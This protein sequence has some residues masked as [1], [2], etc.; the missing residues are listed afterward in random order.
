MW[1]T[2]RTWAV[3]EFLTAVLANEQVRDNMLA[4]TPVVGEYRLFC[5]APTV[6]ETVIGLNY[7][8]CNGASV[9]RSNYSLLYN[10]LN[11]MRVTRG[12][13][14]A[15]LSAAVSSTQTSFS[16][17]GWPSTWPGGSTGGV[18]TDYYYGNSTSGFGDV[19]QPFLVQIDSEKLLVTARGGWPY[20]DFTALR[21]RE[22]T[23][24]ATHNAGALISI[25]PDLPFGSGDGLTT[26]TLPDLHGRAAWSA[27]RA[28]FPSQVDAVGKHDRAW[29]GDRRPAH[30]HS[31]ASGASGTGGS[32][33]PFAAGTLGA[34]RVAG[35]S[36]Y[37]GWSYADFGIQIGPNV[38]SPLDAPSYLVAGVYGIRFVGV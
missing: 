31:W 37:G 22:G 5:R 24:A 8:E 29:P 30:R 1:Q 26:M 38:N 19:D 23:L 25:I 32:Q 36:G 34:G 4:L 33:V 9:S 12:S 14:Q 13:G 18:A 20:T 7:L 28:G 17:A 35:G 21:G 16:I 10:L 11:A 3:G 15:S 27:A 2:P 6:G